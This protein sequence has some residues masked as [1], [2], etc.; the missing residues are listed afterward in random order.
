MTTTYH[1]FNPAFNPLQTIADYIL[2][3]DGVYGVANCFGIRVPVPLLP[4]EVRGLPPLFPWLRADFETGEGSPLQAFAPEE[5]PLDFGPTHH[6]LYDADSQPALD[7]GRLYQ[8]VVGREGVFLLAGIPGLE[9]LMPI[10]GL[11]ALPGLASVSPYVSF[12][13]PLIGEDIA[14]QILAHALAARNNDG[15][16][17]E[18]LYFLLWEERA[19]RLHIPE[20]EAYQGS[21][22]A[23]EVTPEYL[24]AVVEGHSHHNYRANFSHRDDTAEVRD[25]G[26][27]VYFVLGNI[28]KQPEMRVRICVHGYEWEVPASYFF[29]LPEGIVDCVAQEWG[30][31]G[32]AGSH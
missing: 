9:V 5:Q 27:R 19:W 23:K 18:Q 24:A 16:P 17:I 11:T 2:A 32:N 10:S 4:C 8:Y 26:F 12:S 1:L 28:F 25:G 20:Q 14:L 15:Q 3:G 21:V 22:R 13:Y 29:T 31:R 7:P 6:F 30:E